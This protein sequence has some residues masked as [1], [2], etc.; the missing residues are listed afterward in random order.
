MIASLARETFWDAYQTESQLEQKHIRSY[1]DTAFS[2]EV[3]REDFADENII[4][5]VAEDKLGELGYAK[6]AIGSTRKE[7]HTKHTI[8]LCR[9]YLKKESW[10]KSFGSILL[11]KCVEEAE[12]R[13]A[14]VIWLSVWEHNQRAIQFYERQ[15]FE[16][17]GTHIFDLASSLHTDFIM[18]RNLS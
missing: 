3:I 15:G 17:L 5:L 12:K 2:H 14:D 10:G 1:I 6:L 13:D 4:Y 9:I 8:E 16:I 7:I 18:T 11:N